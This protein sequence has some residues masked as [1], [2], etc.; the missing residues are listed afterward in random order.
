MSVLTS[1]TRRR[2]IPL[3]ALP[4]AVACGAA[5]DTAPSGQL[6]TAA[7]GASSAPASQ[8]AALPTT[9]PASALPG[10]TA[11]PAAPA[12]PATG[13]SASPITFKI[14]ADGS[15]A[16]FRVREQLANLPLP[17]DA[18][19]TTNAVTGQISF[20]PAGGLQAEASKVS[21]DL[22]TLKSD[23]GMRDGFIKQ[24]TLQ[25]SQFPTAEFVP[26]RAEGIPSPLP[27]SGEHTFKL[28]GPMTVHGVTKEVTWDVTARREG[29]QLTGKATTA[30]KFGDFGMAAPRVPLVLSIVD[31]I[32][33]ELDLVAS[34][35]S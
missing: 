27:A 29:G 4:F 30:V 12:A 23:S 19:G 9:G 35:A 18:V 7:G 11:A 3:L 8:S 32:R 21:V 1:F 25:T 14:V 5:G 6:G 15:M 16:T 28:T 24:N 20:T 10:A 26:T 31:E 17:N 2:S 13:V 22:S 34:Q 33:L